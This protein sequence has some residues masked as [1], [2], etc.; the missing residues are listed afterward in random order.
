MTDVLSDGSPLNDIS[1]G[2]VVDVR[3]NGGPDWVPA[4]V[5]HTG[6]LHDTQVVVVN[7]ILL[8]SR[9][10]GIAYPLGLVRRHL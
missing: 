4:I 10:R 6:I 3:R 1:A 8:G 7:D 2:A 5:T 9:G